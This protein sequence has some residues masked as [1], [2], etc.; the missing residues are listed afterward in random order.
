MVPQPALKHESRRHA[1]FP[2]LRLSRLIRVRDLGSCGA[3]SLKIEN[4]Q[5]IMKMPLN[6]ESVVLT[7]TIF[8][9]IF[10]NI[11]QS[12]GYQR[13]HSIFMFHVSSHDSAVV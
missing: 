6:L 4:V 7:T 2:P 10:T 12:V 3:E 11:G 1:L 13:K 5:K 9:L 8:F